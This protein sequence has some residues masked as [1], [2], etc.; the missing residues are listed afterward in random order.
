MIRFRAVPGGVLAALLALGAFGVAGAGPGQG[1]AELVAKRKELFEAGAAPGPLYSPSRGVL[2]FELSGAAGDSERHEASVEPSGPS[3]EV[4]A[5]ARRALATW[6]EAYNAGDWRAVTD[7]YSDTPGFHWIEQGRGGYGSKAEIVA[8]IEGFYPHVDNF[9]LEV[10]ETE[11]EALSGELAL[12]TVPYRQE[13]TLADGQR[14]TLAGTMTVLMR[15]SE[16][17]WQA[18]TGHTAAAPESR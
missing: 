6:L 16:E 10:G 17:R 2:A 7:F 15:R 11:V 18:L 5:S 9:A 4:A 8:A 14:L 12:A 13:L 3:A 1:V